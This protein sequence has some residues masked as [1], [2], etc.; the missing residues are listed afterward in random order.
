YT[1]SHGGTVHNCPLFFNLM[2]FSTTPWE[3][4][5][6]TSMLH[7]LTH[8]GAIYTPW[9]RDHGYSY[10]GI[11][12]LNKTKALNNAQSYAYYA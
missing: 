3:M 10:W 1:Y 5:Q 9:T 8:L 7:E 12:R 11:R 4:D 2:Y 6:A